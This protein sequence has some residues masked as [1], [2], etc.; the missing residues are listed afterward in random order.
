[1][2][3]RDKTTFEVTMLVL[4]KSTTRVGACNKAAAEKLA[5]EVVREQLYYNVEKVE[6]VSIVEVTE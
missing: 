3:H 2:K 5:E 6:T 4:V 1:M